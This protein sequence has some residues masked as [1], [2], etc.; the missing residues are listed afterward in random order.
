MAAADSL[1]SEIRR[2]GIARVIYRNF[3]TML[4]PVLFLTKVI[5]KPLE[6]PTSTDTLADDVECRVANS[7]DLHRAIANPRLH[8]SDD[9]LR[10]AEARGDICSAAFKNNEMISYA[11]KAFSYAPHTPDVIVRFAP[12]FCY[13]YKVFTLPEYRGMHIL[14]A[15]S[16]YP[17]AT[18]LARGIT[19][20]ISFIESHNFPSLSYARRVGGIVVGYAGYIRL[21]G[22]IFPFSSPGAKQHGFAFARSEAN[23]QTPKRPRNAHT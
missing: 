9:F 14:E 7:D 5:I 18:I 4:R 1:M 2:W 11:W 20:S 16:T 8:I 12:R 15:A 17:N 10:A 3:M 19:H 23:S 13:S 6:P 21:F 22:R